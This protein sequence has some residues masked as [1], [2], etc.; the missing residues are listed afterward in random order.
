MFETRGIWTYVGDS[1]NMMKHADMTVRV[2]TSIW[3]AF[4]SITRKYTNYPETFL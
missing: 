2:L 4:N 3:E 1:N